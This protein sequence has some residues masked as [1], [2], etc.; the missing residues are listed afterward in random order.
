[1]KIGVYFFLLISLFSCDPHWFNIVVDD[2]GFE[3][4]FNF[5][6][7]KIDISGSVLADKQISI[8]NKI[9]LN[10]IILINP[11]KLK[12][13]YKNEPIKSDIYINGEVIKNPIEVDG[14][15]QMRILINT[16]VQNGDI[17]KIN[18]DNFIVCKEK[19]LEIG[20]INLI[21]ERHK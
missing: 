21:I 4:N 13:T 12:I 19:P 17:L 10:T 6:C 11:E 15:I 1:M 5:E 3:R 7:G 16:I 20:D 14:E 18:I 8:F 9:K 2:N